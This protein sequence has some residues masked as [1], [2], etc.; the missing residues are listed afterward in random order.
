MIIIRDK[1]FYS[2]QEAS[3][4]L[5]LSPMTIKSYIIKG[6]LT[7][8]KIGEELYVAEN[9]LS[10][11]L[12]KDPVKPTK[13]FVARQP[14]FDTSKK[15]FAYELLFRSGL[16]NFYDLS[17]PLDT[18]ASKTISNSFLAI[19]LDT[20]TNGKKAF[21]NFTKNL[22]TSGIPYL[23]PKELII[24]E[25]LEDIEPT[26]DLIEACKQ[27]KKSGFILALDDFI[28]S[29]KLK[30]LIELTDIIKVD[31]LQ[32]KADERKSV[33]ER[34]GDPHIEF[35]AEK[36]E[37]SEDFLEAVDMGYTYFQ[38]YFFSKPL[39]IQGNDIPVNKLNMMKL[40]NEVNKPDTGF[41]KIE[42]IIKHDVSLSYKLLRF[43]NSAFF[44]F[45]SKIESIKHA[46]VLLGEKEVKKWVSLV[47]LSGL[48]YDKPRELINISV[49][50]AKFCESLAEKTGVKVHADDCFLIGMFSLIDALIDK[51]LHDIL[52]EL[53]LA[54]YVKHALLGKH[55][56]YSDLLQLTVAYER[57]EWEIITA[58]S[59]RL[60][61]QEETLPD[62]Y[63][64]SINWANRIN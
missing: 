19:G 2:L 24:V 38:G 26:D 50:R 39:I 11:F 6:L 61:L 46:L 17:T 25:I 16:D 55:N 35:L 28:Y 33:M 27:L 10:N 8:T 62:I 14:I 3:D 43:M 4:K 15:V 36:V 5:H 60:K 44:G 31:F 29:E 32:T 58:N 13:V 30:P 49:L 20:I 9:A 47:A 51:P 52:P 48:A 1:K 18:A 45:N 57:G 56:V 7:G 22:L 37:T 21:I 23:L 63:L 53:P 64:D 59:K 54:E 34:V 41:D 40:I 42:N 12:Q